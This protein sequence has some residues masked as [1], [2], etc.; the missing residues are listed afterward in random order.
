MAV[1]KIYLIRHAEAEGNLYRRIHGWY[2]SL[3][4][5]NGY[6]QI[7]ALEERF[8]DIPVDAVYSSD[9]FR[10]KTTAA[11]IYKPKGLELNTRQALREIG[12]GCWEDM[13]WGEADQIDAEQMHLFNTNHPGFSCDGSETFDQLRQRM[14]QAILKIASSHPG[15]TVAVFSH[16]MAIRNVLAH[17]KGISVAK[18]HEMVPHGDNTS[19][20]LLEVDSGVVDVKYF[21]DNSH[22]PDN[23]STFAS[24]AWWRKTGS[25]KDVNLWFR[26]LDM[27]NNS[28]FYYDAREEAWLNIHGSMLHFD[29]DGFLRDALSHARYDKR[30]VMQAMLNDHPVGLL[31]LDMH[32]DAEKGVGGIPFFYM[33]PEY[34]KNGLGVQLL[35]Q[36]ISV[37]RPMGR[38]YLRLRCA[39]D[40]HIA[41]RFYKRYGFQK[42]G[43]DPGSRVPLDIMEKYIGYEW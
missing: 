8:R 28:Q 9:L 36:A 21:N 25:A 43:E 42:I 4:T 2:D 19:V 16:G 40:N 15:K 29:G 14:S 24:Q 34:R 41:Q 22:L 23:I 38:K 11:S 33:L 5:E 30:C 3:I 31:Q 6:R 39:P 7:A 27:E 35:G 12:M 37:Y 13:T 32:R 17:F 18:T 26:P 10:T 20:S 1:T